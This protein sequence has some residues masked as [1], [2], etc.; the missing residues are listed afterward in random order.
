MTDPIKLTREKPVISDTDLVRE[1][2]YSDPY[3]LF[4]AAS[5]VRPYNPS[6]L[7]ARKGLRIYDQMLRDEQI[8]IA[9]EFKKL[10]VISAG[11]EVVSPEGA[12]DDWEPTLFV[13]YVLGQ[14]SGS[15][16]DKL[17]SILTG[18]AYGFSVSEILWSRKNSGAYAGKICIYD[19]KTRKPHNFDFAQDEF[20]N[21]LSIKQDTHDK[22]LTLPLTKFIVF[23]HQDEF[24]NPYGRS[25]LEAC[26]RAWWAKD[27]AYRWLAMLL[28]RYGIP[29]I[30][31]L[32][33]Q[34]KYSGAVLDRIKDILKNIQAGTAGLLPRNDEKDLELWTP[35][36]AEHVASVFIPALDRYDKDIARG[37]LVTSLLGLTPEEQSGSYAR[38]SVVFDAFMV[39]IDQLRG[40]VANNVVQ[41]KIIKPLIDLNYAVDNYPIFRFK[42]L[43][44]DKR[45]ALLQNWK[46]LLSVAAVTPL[47]EDQAH[48]RDL[49]G[50][51]KSEQTEPDNGAKFS[52]SP[53]ADFTQIKNDLDELEAGFL[54]EA[55]DAIADSLSK[56]EGKIERGLSPG[57]VDR[58]PGLQRIKVSIGNL[59]LDSYEAGYRDIGAE[60]RAAKFREI[61]PKTRPRDALQFL[62][63]K[64]IILASTLS[65][66]IIKEVRSVL[67]AGV[68][69]G[70]TV[71]DM[72]DALRLIFE[73]WVG[74]GRIVDGKQLRPYRLEAIARTETTAA[75]NQ[76][77]LVR[78]RAE[79]SRLVLGF[80]YDAILDERTSDVCRHL[81]GKVFRLNDKDLD[82]LSPP[83]HVNC[84]SIL[85][86]VTIS[87]DPPEFVSSADKGRAKD[88]AGKGFAGPDSF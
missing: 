1:L 70:M 50:F 65:A 2:S 62:R 72:I 6:D 81:D 28:E 39:V 13:R 85:V 83:N 76:G 71:K 26:Y 31:L 44:Q 77:R 16:D 34:Q 48:I 38:A 88:L 7:V 80:R 36:I 17:L 68:E 15:L 40:R 9:L 27:N 43:T 69:T 11:W 57:A 46:E 64:G 29:P 33:N 41:D 84:R 30:F 5:K 32:F 21:T 37:L 75:Y 8:K 51:P 54:E 74:S 18:L 19:I 23:S 20:G 45:I 53:G 25:D 47:P 60:T 82:T 61:F 10:A 14:I 63:S 87:Q 12:P 78:A 86:P 59:L 66:E 24:Q 73:P 56:I 55:T 49:L 58:L 79:L 35:E 22:E 3:R 42:A 52:Q 67:L 4:S